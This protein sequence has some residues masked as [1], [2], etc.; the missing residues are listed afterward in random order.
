MMFMVGGLQ[1]AGTWILE[2]DIGPGLGRGAA[3]KLPSV[4]GVCLTS[5]L[6]KIWGT[7]PPKLMLT[8]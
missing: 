3:P 7:Y 1:I 8:V 6:R 4:W 5:T 2:F